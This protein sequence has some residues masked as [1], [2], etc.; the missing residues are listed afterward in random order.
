MPSYRP[1]AVAGLFYSSDPQ[2]LDQQIHRWLDVTVPG[3]SDH[4]PK[5]LVVPHAGYFS[6]GEIAALA[7]VLL[8][9]FSHQIRRVVLLGPT[10]RHGL[11]GMAIPSVDVF[12]TPIGPITLDRKTMADLL[13]N[14]EVMVSDEAHAFEHSLEVQLPFLKRV[15][16]DFV[17]VPL[18]IGRTDSDAVFGVVEQLWGGDET[19]VI[20]ST[21]LSHFL[22]STR[23]SR[24]DR[25]TLEKIMR[26]SPTLEPEDACGALALNGVLR[27][28][29]QRGLHA[30]LLAATH[31]GITTGDMR[32]VV[33]Y[34]TV[35]LW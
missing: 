22:T 29:S 32:R 21:D 14:S 3:A 34:G 13:M 9:P 8:K 30:K 33:G 26:L 15:L 25:Q 23:A 20:V 7:Y 24:R 17:M 27:A 1:P 5:V 18:A 35:A 2:I 12:Q 6:S 31:S 19:L 4:C 11:H 10:H 16:T 28:S